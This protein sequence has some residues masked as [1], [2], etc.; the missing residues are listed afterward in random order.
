MTQEEKQWREENS[1]DEQLSLVSTW[2]DYEDYDIIYKCKTMERVIE[3]YLFIQFEVG[4]EF[5][6]SVNDLIDEELEDGDTTTLGKALAFDKEHGTDFFTT[7]EL[8]DHYTRESLRHKIS[9][10]LVDT[11]EDNPLVCDITIGESQEQGLSSLELP[12]V[13]GAFHDYEARIWFN[14]YGCNEPMDFDDLPTEDLI[15]IWENLTNK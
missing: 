15:K 7:K 14:L 13:V 11:A 9:A 12:R 10:L 5:V 8:A 1:A 6:S 3:L 4:V 2:C